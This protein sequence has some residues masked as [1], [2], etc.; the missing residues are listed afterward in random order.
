MH[1]AGQIFEWLNRREKKQEQE[2]D[3]ERVTEVMS[4]AAKPT[5]ENANRI[6][7]WL[8]RGR[9]GRLRKPDPPESR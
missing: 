3:N 4:A 9:T 5:Q 8:A 1:A 2:E 7:E 6:N